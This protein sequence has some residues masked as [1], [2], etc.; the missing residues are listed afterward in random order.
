MKKAAKKSA[1]VVRIGEPGAV[2]A[3]RRAAEEFN[4]K[5]NRSKRTARATLVRE[6]ILTPGGKLTANYR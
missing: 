6:G 4:R 5:A 2:E 3:F 1:I